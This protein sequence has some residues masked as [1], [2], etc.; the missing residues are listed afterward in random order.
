MAESEPLRT[1][2]ISRAEAK[3]VK[4]ATLQR[5]NGGRE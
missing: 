4:Q 2:D 1:G 5:M 3:L